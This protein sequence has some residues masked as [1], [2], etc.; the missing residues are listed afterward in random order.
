MDESKWLTGSEVSE[1][2]RHLE[3]QHRMHRTKKGQRRL[4]LFGCAC[5]RLIWDVMTDERARQAVVLAERYADGEVGRAEMKEF[6]PQH[7]KAFSRV[8]SIS[9]KQTAADWAHAATISLVYPGG[10]GTTFSTQYA[11]MAAECRG[12]GGPAYLPPSG[13][14]TASAQRQADLLR[15]VFGNPFRPVTV[16]ASVLSWNDRAV[17]KLAQSVY[18]E[19]AFDRLPV[20]ADALE[21]AGC[22][23]ADV[24][25]HC[26]RPGEHVRGCWVVDLLQG[27]L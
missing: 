19:R 7:A 12:P 22:A 15:D 13:P 6:H 24:L 14:R 8:L 3:N 1:M 9:H 20:L 17:P 23:D 4:R 27:R 25:G 26:R 18:Q 5:C 11:R 21:D 2:I 16:P 10:I